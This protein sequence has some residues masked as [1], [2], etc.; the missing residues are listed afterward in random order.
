MAIRQVLG[1]IGRFFVG[2]GV[3]TQ[4]TFDLED[5]VRKSPFRGLPTGVEVRYGNGAS[6]TLDGYEVTVTFN[7]PPQGPNPDPYFS[8]QDVTFYLFFSAE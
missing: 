8:T 5:D 3:S 6:A 4:A 1:P 2:D 7:S